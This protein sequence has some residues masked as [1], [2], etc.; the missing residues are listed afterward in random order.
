[1]RHVYFPVES[2]IA[3][4]APMDDGAIQV[5]MVGNEGM[6]GVSLMLGARTSSLRGFVQGGGS[7]WKMG[8]GPFR[9]EVDRSP[10]LRQTLNRYLCVLI[11]QLAQNTGCARFHLV[12]ARLARWLLMA[13]DRAHRNSFFITHEFLSDMLGVRRVGVTNAASALQA[14]KLIRYS[15]G[16]VTIL[17]GRGLEAVACEC[18]RAGDLMYESAL[19]SG[20]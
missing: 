15:R 16:N 13:R 2:F 8:D 9:Q 3:M 20:A 19:G 17:N 6:V 5:G 11:G 10:A 12:D 4:V 7:A 14:A 1:M 18:Y